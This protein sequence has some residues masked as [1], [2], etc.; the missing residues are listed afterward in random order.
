LFLTAAW[1]KK[2]IEISQKRA[3]L[4][5]VVAWIFRLPDIDDMKSGRQPSRTAQSAKCSINF[6]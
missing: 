1:A 5:L 3:N 2:A 6:S 4:A